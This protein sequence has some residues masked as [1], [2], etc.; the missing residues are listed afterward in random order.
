MNPQ[1]SIKIFTELLRM[2]CT[3]LM[4]ML[5]RLRQEDLEFEFRLEYTAPGLHG[6]YTSTV[7]KKQKTK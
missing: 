6:Q 2:G 1:N 3:L 4:Q 7:W 5:G